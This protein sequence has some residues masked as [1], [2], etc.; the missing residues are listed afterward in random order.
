MMLQQALRLIDNPAE[1][2]AQGWCGA[3]L[4]TLSIVAASVCV[5]KNCFHTLTLSPV[6]DHL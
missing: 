5:F 1:D 6:L 4:S 2:D 3:Y